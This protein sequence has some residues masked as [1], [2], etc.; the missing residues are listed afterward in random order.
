ML[1]NA[2]GA[3]GFRLSTADPVL[4]SPTTET[5]TAFKQAATRLFGVK[6]SEIRALKDLLSRRQ[7]ST[8]TVSS[9]MAELR[10]L[11]KKTSLATF[12]NGEQNA[13]NYILA[14]MLTLGTKST[15][16][17]KRLL[18]EETI[19]LTEFVNIA[20]SSEAA[21]SDQQR[22]LSGGQIRAVDQRGRT[23]QGES[24]RGVTKSNEKR[25]K[26]NSRNRPPVTV[27]MRC[28]RN[29]R[30]DDP[31]TCPALHR[32]CTKCGKTGHFNRICQSHGPS[33]KH[34][35]ATVRFAVPL[36]TTAAHGHSSS[37]HLQAPAKVLAQ[38]NIN[39]IASLS[40]ESKWNFLLNFTLPSGENVSVP[41]K[42]DTGADV[43]IVTSATYDQH[44]S[45]IP[46]NPPPAT[47]TNFD[48]TPI[49]G[50]RGA[51]TAYVNHGKQTAKLTVYVVPN[52][53]ATTAGTDAIEKLQLVL[54]GTTRSARSITTSPHHQHLENFRSLTSTELG[55]YP[56][57]EHNIMLRAAAHPVSQK[58]RAI[59]F[60]KRDIVKAEI[61]RMIEQGIWEP[62]SRSDW[63]HG[64]V[65]V[66]KPDG[67]V[68]I[69][70]DL[71]P[72]NRHVVPARHLPPNI[73]E[74]HA[75]LAGSKI[76][77][78]LDLA[79]A[80]YHI[81][82]SEASR[83]LTAT[84]TPWGLYQ[85][86]RLPMG[87]KDSSAVFQRCVEKALADI[88]GCVIYIDD[89]LIHA[90]SQQQHDDVLQLVLNRLQQ[91]DF[92]LN[93][94][95]CEFN[96]QR[97][98]FLGNIISHDCIQADPK[99]LQG[100]CDMPNPSNVSQLQSF[101]GAV[102]HYRTFLRG[103]AAI[104]S[105]L[106]RLLRK[107]VPW[108]WGPQQQEAMDILRQRLGQLPTL[109]TFDPRRPTIVTT[110]ASSSGLGAT[111]S[112]L[113][114]NQEVPIAYASH[115]LTQA[116]RN[117]ATNEREALAVLWALE[118]WES[119]LLGYEF[120]LRSDH[121]PLAALLQHSSQRKR[122]K[123]I[124]WADRL[125]RFNYTFQH[126]SGAT[127]VVADCL[128][129]LPAASSA[130][131]DSGIDSVP[132]C[133]S[134]VTEG[135]CMLDVLQS[136][137]SDIAYKQLIQAVLR[138]EW[139]ADSL[140]AFRQ[141]RDQLD[142]REERGLSYVVKNDRIVVPSG[143]RRRILSLAHRGHPG[144]V[145]MKQKLRSSYW[146]PAMDKEAESPSRVKACT[147]SLSTR[148]KRSTR[149]LA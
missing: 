122:E 55:T 42:L 5:Y 108:T 13:E 97:I 37:Q 63:A 73:R 87:L 7:Q 25:N 26:S 2:I 67:G 64:L 104:A 99:R 133:I 118:H 66:F 34:A 111:L 10:A 17:Q 22:L 71:T 65:P 91:Y 60:A 138:N 50:V 4:S 11:A 18:R 126:I 24:R 131:N 94:T 41:S 47:L 15:A 117:Y 19:A 121:K 88:P 98:S 6:G 95:K 27:C 84:I 96:C 48:S 53:M 103:A 123:F 14:A 62:C 52:H 68:R 134:R 20:S 129:R 23:L 102:N 93:T 43:T 54:D 148:L 76:F 61:N 70:T 77:S 144:I 110:D 140:R 1:L 58:V 46:L 114:K 106:Q 44:L 36:T 115:A 90:P 39:H 57:F 56:A 45:T 125:S 139:K 132:V 113:E 141:V 21:D 130:T 142:T 80:Y 59:P 86:Q 143:L 75:L 12:V 92:R 38:A 28:G 146:W 85:Y 149:P 16:I 127:N 30:H 79:K 120:L 8:E 31:S 137:A 100:I 107:G 33:A 124:R 89:I 78:R 35:V 105:P 40:E 49:E 116:E 147:P 83:P 72:L 9:F 101:L 112:Q 128:S 74:V 69:T 135:I 119:Y 82:L 81:Q 3:E 51:F 145:R 32:Q 29:G 136:I 109:H